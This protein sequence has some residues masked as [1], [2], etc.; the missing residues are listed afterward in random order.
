MRKG[1]IHPRLTETPSHPFARHEATGRPGGR[2]PELPTGGRITVRREACF[3]GGEAR[4]RVG[5]CAAASVAL[6]VLDWRG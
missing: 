2:A 6:G 5:A 1:N 4:L 3:G